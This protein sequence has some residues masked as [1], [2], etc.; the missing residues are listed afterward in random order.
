MSKNKRSQDLI[1][2]VK[3]WKLP[4][5]E[6]LQYNGQSY[7]ELNDLWQALYQTFNLAQNNQ[8]NP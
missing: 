8:V 3:K 4:A 1:N 5:T 2:Q 6:A 7:I